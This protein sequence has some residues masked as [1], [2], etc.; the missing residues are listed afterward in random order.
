MIWVLL[1]L[2]LLARSAVLVHQPHRSPFASEVGLPHGAGVSFL[3]KLARTQRCCTL[4][5]GRIWLALQTFQ[6]LNV[7]VLLWLNLGL[8][9][10][11]NDVVVGLSL[12]PLVS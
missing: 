4:K 2:L 5:C 10:V 3:A 6:A 12:L 8:G 9:A 1:L 7:V 11:C